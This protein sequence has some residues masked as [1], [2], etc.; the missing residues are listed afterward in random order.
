MK[1]VESRN[2]RFEFDSA[3]PVLIVI[4]P[5]DAGG[6]RTCA[7][8]KMRPR[9]NPSGCEILVGLAPFCDSLRGRL[10]RGMSHSSQ[11]RDASLRY[12]PTVKHK[13][14]SSLGSLMSVSEPLN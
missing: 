2:C 14:G 3:E 11:R 12:H 8:T 6:V 10:K 7:H 9:A 1:V 13:T 5:V 4:V